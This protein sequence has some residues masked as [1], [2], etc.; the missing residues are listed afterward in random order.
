MNV[1]A[2]AV[3]FSWCRMACFAGM[4]YE[5]GQ[6]VLFHRKFP[7]ILHLLAQTEKT[8]EKR[9]TKQYVGLRYC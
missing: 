7:I 3:V 9:H 4:V 1:E 6:L 8:N 2:E 5:A